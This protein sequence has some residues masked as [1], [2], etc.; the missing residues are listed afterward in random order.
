MAI[1]CK[2]CGAP[3]EEDCKFCTVCGAPL[4]QTQ[5]AVQTAPLP[6]ENSAPVTRVMPQYA[7]DEF[8]P[9]TQPDKDGIYAPLSTLGYVG[10][11]L[12]GCVPLVGL[13]FM[14]IWACGGCRKVAQMHFARAYIVLTILALLCSFV[15][16]LVYF[17]A[18]TAMLRTVL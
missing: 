11:M 4:E 9:E 12:L 15:F 6:A 3:L 17:D 13:V 8:V 7:P 1:I 16:G 2:S 5:P 10:L 18:I 14:I